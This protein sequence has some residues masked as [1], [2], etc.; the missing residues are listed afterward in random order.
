MASRTITVTTEAYEALKA[1][2]GPNESFS[3]AIL[4]VFGRRSPREFFGA[5]PAG[6]ADRL[7]RAVRAGRARHAAER[8]RR[9]RRVAEGL[10][11]G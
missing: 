10:R 5:L 2:K 3:E 11:A 7:E 1:A 8:K 6:T 9:M 4:R